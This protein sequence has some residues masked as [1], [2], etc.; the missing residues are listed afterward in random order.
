MPGAHGAILWGSCAAASHSLSDSR[1][2]SPAAGAAQK[3]GVTM[4][5][6]RVT[7]A[8]NGATVREILAEW[9]RV[10]QTRIVNGERVT[11]APDHD[12]S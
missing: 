2:R 9:A 4:K 1:W 7:L 3:S 5:D 11:G 6:G 10:G 12:R 8:A